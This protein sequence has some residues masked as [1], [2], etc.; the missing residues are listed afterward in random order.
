MGCYIAA[1]GYLVRP[2]VYE[3]HRIS[4][5]GFKKAFTEELL[6]INSEGCV[7]V[8]ISNYY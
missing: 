2:K 7:K 8:L 4:D 3:R 6:M 1:K 5:G